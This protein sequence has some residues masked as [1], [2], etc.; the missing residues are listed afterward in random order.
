MDDERA[1]PRVGV[2]G[3]SRSDFPVLE[4]ATM[5]DRVV[6]QWPSGSTQEFASVAAGQYECREGSGIAPVRR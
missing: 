6:V 3:G 2:V 5:V 4:K 1:A